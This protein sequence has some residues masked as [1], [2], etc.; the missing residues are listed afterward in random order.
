M[1]KRSLSIVL[2]LVLLQGPM[3]VASGGEISG[4]D[5]GMGELVV[6]FNAPDYSGGIEIAIPAECYILNASMTLCGLPAKGDTPAFPTAPLLLLND[7]VLWTFDGIGY[8]ALG[9]QEELVAGTPTRLGIGPEGGPNITILR[10]PKYALVESATLMANCSGES[11]IQEV[12]NLSGD[13]EGF[14][15]YYISWAGDINNDGCDDILV[16]GALNVSFFLG[17]SE[18]NNTPV[19]VFSYSSSGM[20]FFNW[21]VSSAGDMNKDGYDDII[22]GAEGKEYPGGLGSS[23]DTAFIHFGGSD[24]D[25]EPDVILEG[26]PRSGFGYPVSNAGDVNADGYDDVIVGAPREEIGGT[27]KVGRA[28]IFLGGP[29]VDEMPDVIMTSL[30]SSRTYFGSTVA[31][32]GDLNGDGFDDVAVGEAGRIYLYFGGTAMDNEPDGILEINEFWNGGALSC[33]DSGDINGDNYNDIVVGVYQSSINGFLSGSVYIYYG[34]AKIDYNPDVVIN[35]EKQRDY[36]GTAVSG[37]GDMNGDGYD[38]VIAG[39]PAFEQTNPRYGQVFLY[40]GSPDMDNTSDVS[41]TGHCINDNYGLSISGGGDGNGDGYDDLLVGASKIDKVYIYG[42]APLNMILDPQIKVGSSIIFNESGYVNKTADLKDFSAALNSYLR[43]A[44]VCGTDEYGNEY[45]DVPIV[46]EARSEGNITLSALNITYIYNATVPDFS[47]A[48]NDYISRNKDKA[49]ASG[50]ITVPLELRSASA[51][52]I[53]VFSLNI[54]YD[55][56]PHLLSPIPD[57][58]MDE[59]TAVSMLIDLYS[60]FEDDYDQ[61]TGLTFAIEGATNAAFVT[62]EICENRYVSADALTGVANDNWTGEV[63]MRVAALDGRGLRTESNDFKIIVRNVND[64]PLITSNPMTSVPNA[65]LYSYNVTAVDGDNDSLLFDLTIKPEGMT[66]NSS[67]GEMSWIPRAGGEYPVSLSVSDG[68]ATSHQNFTIS[69]IQANR[70]PKFASAP[71]TKATV[72]KEYIYIARATDDDGDALS[73][74]LSVAP[75]GM[76]INGTTGNVSWTPAAGQEGSHNVTVVVMDGRG[77]EGRQTFAIKVSEA[78][79]LKPVCTITRPSPGS[80]VSGRVTVSGWAMKAEA[81]LREIRIRI[82]G[83]AWSMAAGTENWTYG[84]DTTKL[85]NGKHVISAVAS[86]GALESDI[87]SVEILVSNPEP[88]ISVEGAAWMVH[89]LV[90]VAA[91]CMVFILILRSRGRGG[92]AP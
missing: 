27:S 74:S 64:A 10:L 55:G 92:R 37:A 40:L 87:A 82:D 45:V 57:A 56:A 67:S 20:I 65:T 80:R 46:V 33:L 22:C 44:P 5:G 31:S 35:G 70:P 76:L 41:L 47:G 17:G 25:N 38:D 6:E 29:V 85:K 59:D 34:G 53:K 83:G 28:Y 77:G 62:V 52:R 12:A 2:A 68:L 86:D 81:D 39:S 30:N 1:K 54:T 71:V 21:A 89:A 18:Y 49:D 78:R 4:F 14:L 91:A 42:G 50:N 69:V 58:I 16:G 3:S 73:Y 11:K 61:K 32:A 48:L 51:G 84:L 75:D 60:Y 24:I 43:E 23:G 9:M 66:I 90:L 15:S 26:I 13:S 7:T 88:R 19:A 72:G 79:P 36:L 63:Q 8:G